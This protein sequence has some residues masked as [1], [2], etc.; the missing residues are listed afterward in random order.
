MKH[1]P[2]LFNAR[3]L[4]NDTRLLFKL[5]LLLGTVCAYEGEVPLNK[6]ELASRMKTSTYRIN[7]LL[8][9]LEIEEVIHYDKTG[10]L[11]FNRYRFIQ[12]KE[13]SSKEDLYSKNFVFFTS[14]E[15]L[16]ED[17]N[18]QRFV[19]HAV[20]YKLVYLPKTF[21]WENVDALYG[22]IGLLN[23]R[24]RKEALEVIEKASKYLCLRMSKNKKNFQVTG[25]HKKWLDLGEIH[26]EGSLLWVE[27][28]LS[29]HRFCLEFISQ[30]AIIQ[31]AKVMEYYYA[32]FG[33]QFSTEIFDTALHNI[34]ADPARSNTFFH[35][36]YRENDNYKIS[37]LNEISAYFR[38]VMQSAELSYSKQLEMELYSHHNTKRTAEQELFKDD[39]LQD[40][41]EILVSECN[42]KINK[43]ISK[44]SLLQKAWL[45]R[46]KK[47]PQWL[48]Q[49]KEHIL[50]LPLGSFL[51]IRNIVREME[52]KQSSY[53]DEAIPF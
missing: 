49:H 46:I 10:K 4:R 14:D 42:R 43:T 18:V 38:A 8:K 53:S 26:S 44:L 34:Q 40:E 28:Q 23:I 7:L 41:N 9:K 19:L 48:V 51:E 27:K 5:K 6:K 15:F 22:E 11:F 13:E 30:K 12:E 3:T 17:R 16:E 39:V 36:I 29:K 31:I 52:L 45:N 47:D 50:S 25:V 37:E 35:M 21:Y 20:G 2:E 32:Q 1:D 24:T 33:Y